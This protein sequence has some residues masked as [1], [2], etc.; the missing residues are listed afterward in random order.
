MNPAAKL[1]AF[2]VAL[3]LVFG[4]GAVLGAAVGPDDSTPAPTHGHTPTT[5][6]EE[7]AP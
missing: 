7:G 2:A 5:P 4:G 1:A 6:H 3:A